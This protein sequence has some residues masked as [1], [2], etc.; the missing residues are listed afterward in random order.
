MGN[1]INT[2]GRLAVDRSEPGS[3]FANSIDMRCYFTNDGGK[4][5]GNSG[6]GEAVG[7]AAARGPWNNSGLVV[8]TTWHYYIDPHE[9]KRHYI[10]YTDIG[11]AR[12][13]DAGK[14][15]IWW[16]TSDNFQWRNTCYEL[17]IDPDVP[18]RIWGAF[19]KMH[20]IPN[21][22][23]ISGRHGKP[24]TDFGGDLRVGGFRGDVEG[25]S[26]AGCR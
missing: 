3:C 22:N 9:P 20:D 18:G 15:W 6:N 7:H 12:S 2:I 5:V 17:A 1:I 23:I 10:C 16:K 19:S 8:T 24:R 26:K 14:T 11:F 4:N 13:L 25:R 21:M